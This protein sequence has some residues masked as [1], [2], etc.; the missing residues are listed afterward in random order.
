MRSPAEEEMKAR[1]RENLDIS[2]FGHVWELGWQ[3][4]HTAGYKDGR[5]SVYGWK[6]NLWDL[7]RFAAAVA[8]FLGIVGLAHWLGL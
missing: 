5:D 4:G 7:A 2:I 6:R 3:A 1:V 8:V